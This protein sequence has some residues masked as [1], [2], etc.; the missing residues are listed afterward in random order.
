MFVAVGISQYRKMVKSQVL[1][2][3]LKKLKFDFDLNA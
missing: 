3:D 2:F 1:T